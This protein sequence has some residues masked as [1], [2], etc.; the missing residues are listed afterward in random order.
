MKRAGTV[1]GVRPFFGVL[2]FDMCLLP[3]KHISYYQSKTKIQNYSI[4]AHLL[5]SFSSCVMRYF[6]RAPVIQSQP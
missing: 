2:A 3:P 4:R 5:A 1:E 6:I